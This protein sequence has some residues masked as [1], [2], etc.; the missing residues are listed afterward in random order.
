MQPEHE[1]EFE[2]VPDVKAKII[3][4]MNVVNDVAE[5]MEISDNAEVHLD[6]VYEGLG[7]ILKQ[8]METK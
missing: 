3:W 6:D 8:I 1:R 2:M 7:R 4:V 5:Y